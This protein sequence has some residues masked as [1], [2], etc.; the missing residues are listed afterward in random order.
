MKIIFFL[1]IVFTY[2]FSFLGKNIKFKAIFADDETFQIKT[3]NENK[4]EVPRYLI[5]SPIKSNKKIVDQGFKITN[6]EAPN[7]NI[8]SIKSPNIS[9]FSFLEEGFKLDEFYISFQYQL[10]TNLIFGNGERVHEFLLNPG[11]YT[12]WPNDTNTPYD[13]G[14]GGY[15]LYGIHSF[16]LNKCIVLQ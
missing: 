4:Y 14:T 16:I 15:N 9:V 12:S 1:L 6:Y 8:F 10:T 7:F 5:K 13:E 3:L 11:I 2:S